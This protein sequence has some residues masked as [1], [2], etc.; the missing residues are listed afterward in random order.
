[1]TA[2]WRATGVVADDQQTTRLQTA[3]PGAWDQRHF[4]YIRIRISVLA[5]GEGEGEWYLG[6]K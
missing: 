2:N 5:L 3:E 4:L 1:M 6:G